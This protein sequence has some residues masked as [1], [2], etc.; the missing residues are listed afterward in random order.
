MMPLDKETIKKLEKEKEE[1]ET[2]IKSL[3]STKDEV[4]GELDAI[5]RKLGGRISELDRQM[6]EAAEEG[7]RID[8]LLVESANPDGNIAPSEGRYDKYELD[9]KEEKIRKRWL[10][11]IE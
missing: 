7:I 9:E 2:R 3:K 5:H 1:A 11:L 4:K 10:R 8:T 6:R